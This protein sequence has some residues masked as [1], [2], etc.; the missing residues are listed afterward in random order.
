[1]VL[2]Q[3]YTATLIVQSLGVET[4]AQRHDASQTILAEIDQLLTKKKRKKESRH[5]VMCFT[6]LYSVFNTF[7]VVVVV[8]FYLVCNY[9][10]C[11]DTIILEIFA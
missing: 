2:E 4:G 1:M 5:R 10:V 8:Y 6:T 11:N 7:V 3:F 9:L